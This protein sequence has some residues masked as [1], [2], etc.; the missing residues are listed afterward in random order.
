[1][2]LQKPQVDV[3]LFTNRL[4]EMQAFYGQK[5]GLQFESMMP[6]GGGF[7]QY[8]YLANGSVIKLMNT[9]E[10]LRPRRPG[11][12]ETLMIASSKVKHGDAFPDPDDNTIELVPPGA[13]G[14][15]QIEIRVGVIDPVEHGRFYTQAF[16]A[17]ALGGDRYR[18]GETIF[19]VYHEPELHRPAMHPFANALEVVQ[20]MAELGMQ[21]VTFG[22]R[23]CA[24][25]FAALKSAGASEAVAPVDFGTVA[26]IAFVRDPDGNFIELAQRPPA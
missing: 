5:L 26:K 23:D 17:V 19:G 14:V 8:R 21:Y 25:A 18:I 2:E 20:A 12:Y 9:R 24:A 10:P 16:G 13:N 22:V 7:R 11:G 6:V 4:E 1:M 3:G 15:T